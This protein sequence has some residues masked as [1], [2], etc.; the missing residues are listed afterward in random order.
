[1]RL[2]LRVSTLHESEPHLLHATEHAL[3]GPATEFAGVVVNFVCKHDGC[4]GVEISV[5]GLAFFVPFREH[6]E[7][8]VGV[9]IQLRVDGT[10]NAHADTLVDLPHVVFVPLHEKFL[11]FNLERDGLLHFLRLLAILTEV[12]EVDLRLR[13]FFH[14]KAHTVDAVDIQRLHFVCC[15]LRHRLPVQHV[16]FFTFF[17]EHEVCKLFE[18]QIP[19]K[20]SLTRA[21]NSSCRNIGHKHLGEAFLC[22]LFDNWITKNVVRKDLSIKVGQFK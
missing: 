10:P 9:V 16:L 6:E 11:V 13:S 17:N 21:H 14:Q 7:V 19:R 2:C 20:H 8:A 12:L 3:N 18:D 1:M 22:D 5:P 4:L 15:S